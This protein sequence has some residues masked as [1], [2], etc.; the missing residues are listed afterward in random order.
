M[1]KNEMKVVPTYRFQW[2]RQIKNATVYGWDNE[3]GDKLIDVQ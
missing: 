1:P 3:F 2:D